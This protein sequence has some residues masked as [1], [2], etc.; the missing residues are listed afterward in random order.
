MTLAVVVE[1]EMVHITDE[2]RKRLLHA[3][4]TIPFLQQVLVETAPVSDLGEAVDACFF[5]FLRG[6]VALI[7]ENLHQNFQVALLPG[8]GLNQGL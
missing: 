5:A 2:E 7:D 8:D 6:I 1:L 3:N 4:V